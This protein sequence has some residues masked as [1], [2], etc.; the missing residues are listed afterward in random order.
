MSFRLK[1]LQ[2]QA[3]VVALAAL[4]ASGGM[5]YGDVVL[6]DFTSGV[7]ESSH[8]EGAGQSGVWYDAHNQTFGTPTAGTLDGDPAM[9]ITDGGFTNGV[10]AVFE[11][12]VPADG[13]YSIELQ[14]DIDESGSPTG[15]SAYQVGVAVGADAV[16]RGP[17]PSQLPGLSIVQDYVGLTPNDDTANEI[18]TITTATFSASAGDS[19]LVAL[20]TDVTTGDWNANS[21]AWSGNTV[22][23]DNITLKELAPPP[24]SET[25]VVDD[26][27]GGVTAVNH[28]DGAGQYNV[29]YDATSVTFGT[30][31]ASTLEGSD[32]LR[33]DDGGFTNGVYA[34]YPSAIP[35]DG[36]YKL[37]VDINVVES[38]N[39][40]GI[41]GY[42]VGTAVGADAVH[43]DSALP[44]LSIAGTYI[45]LTPNDDTA[46][47][48]QTVQT[49]LFEASA[50]DDLLVALGTDVESGGW[51][52]NS[53]LWSGSHVLAD[54]IKLRSIEVEPPPFALV[55]DNDDGEPVYTSN[56]F[57][58]SGGAGYDGGTY[59]FASVGVE[60]SEATWTGTIP[61]DGFYEISAI[62]R[63]GSNRASI[64]QYE[65]STADGIVETTTDQRVNNLSWVLLGNY[66]LNE[67]E[68]TVTL[69]AEN[70]ENPGGSAVVIADAIRIRELDGPPPI[71]DPEIRLANLLVF[72]G[73][74]DVGAIQSWINDISWRR[75]NSVAVHTRYRG[76][77]TYIPNKSDSTFENNEPRNPLVGSVDVLEET[78]TRGH[79]AGLKV[80]AYVNTML[81]TDGADSDPRPNHIVNQHPEW[82][83]Y[84]YNG[85]NP[86]QQT[87]A[88]NPDGLWLD[89]A[90][91]EVRAYT[92]EVVAD[93]VA[94]YDVDGVIFDRHRYPQ[95]TFTRPNLDFGYHPDAIAAFNEEYGKEGTPDPYDEDWI[96]FRQD[97]ITRLTQRLFSTV[98]SINPDALVLSYPIGR[99]N[100]A[101]N[102]NY[103]DWPTWMDNQVMDVVLPQIYTQDTSLFTS[104]ASTHRGAYEGDRL[105]GITLDV[106]R[107]GTD[108]PA[109][110]DI[111]RQLGFDGNALFTHSSMGELGYFDL[112]PEAWPG[113]AAFPET[114]WKAEPVECEGLDLI[115]GEGDDVLVGTVCDE[116]I[117]GGAGSDEITASGGDDMI[118]PDVQGERSDD[119]IDGGDGID[120]VDYSS[121][122]LPIRVDLTEGTARGFSIGED[123]VLNV[124]N[125][126]GRAGGADRIIG[127][128]SANHIFAAGL[129]DGEGWGGADRVVGLGG[130]DIIELGGPNGGS[131]A[132]AAWGGEGDDTINGA[133]RK[134]LWLDG[135]PGNDTITAYDGHHD[136]LVGGEGDDTLSGGGGF[137][138]VLIGGPGDDFIDGGEGRLDRVHFSGSYRDYDICID[139]NGV[140]TV[141]DLVGDDGTD[142]VQNVEMFKFGNRM[143]RVERLNPAPC[144]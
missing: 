121:A 133:S 134:N 122:R 65:L 125:I 130:D 135:G 64:A 120:T 107:P 23:V 63:A 17:N 3:P 62:F 137:G 94:N 98:V 104:R 44:G 105:L 5:A 88:E 83:T 18:Q 33:I 87:T 90:L 57:A 74:D 48:T 9:T 15:F 13:D 73:L 116:L 112:L 35:A 114:P 144:E 138:D 131:I 132:S 77:A 139:E 113:I 6:A 68:F 50:G 103:Q 84:A 70:S 42:Q 141:T 95:T 46:N 123:V 59:Q 124:E 51:N 108:L 2:R 30:P 129:E 100:D 66:Q 140:I 85:G 127:N 26:F 142:K 79:E 72:D 76:D 136:V 67:G 128:D 61:E 119:F 99:F 19:V 11:G 43:R 91:P 117:V 31:S 93:I 96:Q 14:M 40:D 110:V 60:G 36:F 45:G 22:T 89:P 39:V 54:N 111:S 37:E 78:V 27:S 101:V 16:H 8:P 126:I 21:S 7:S 56:G 53:S 102:F 109:Q 69:D 41:R 20:G 38:G 81:V 58:T 1:K 71:D 82:V 12:V 55:L 118:V 28:P 24:P 80:F 75:Y 92:A 34:I 32:A 106:F 97:A 25:T 143:F 86:V 49:G 4:L 52:A 10:Y 29:W 115:G 47:E